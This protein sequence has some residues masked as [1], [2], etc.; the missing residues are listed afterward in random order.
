[1]KHASLIG[2]GLSKNNIFDLTNPANRDNCFE[3]YAAL[4]AGFQELGIDLST[5][6]LN[7]GKAI[8]FE[9]HQNVQRGGQ[10]RNAYLMLFETS[11][12][13]PAN[14]MSR[15]GFWVCNVITSTHMDH[16]AFGPLR[17]LSYCII[18]L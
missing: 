5:S 6:D 17:L 2:G 16:D 1:M 18:L 7:N 14:A 11:I 3:P 4:R 8:A 10:N 9:L 13:R 12:V 15:K